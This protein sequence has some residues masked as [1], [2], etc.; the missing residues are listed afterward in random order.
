ML[1]IKNHVIPAEAGIQEMSY[2]I[3]K[4]LLTHDLLDF[5][6]RGND[7]SFVKFQDRA[8]LSLKKLPQQ[9]LL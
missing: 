9:E 4:Y 7:H 2:K 5:R 8:T 6:F 3:D 1:R